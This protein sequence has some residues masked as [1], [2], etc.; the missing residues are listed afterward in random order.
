MPHA[1]QMFRA[2]LVFVS[3]NNA[4]MLRSHV[5][6]IIVMEMENAH[7]LTKSEKLYQIVQFSILHALL[8]VFA[9][10]IDLEVV[11]H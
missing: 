11:V 2:V 6:T 4:K 5:Q 8:V 3:N 9:M 7:F 10:Q 1:V